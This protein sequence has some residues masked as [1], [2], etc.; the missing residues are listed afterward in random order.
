VTTALVGRSR[1]PQNQQGDADNNLDY[2]ELVQVSSA[3]PVATAATTA[4]GNCLTCPV[5]E[6]ARCVAPDVLS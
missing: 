2:Q 6:G 5:D 3:P 1:R 4:S